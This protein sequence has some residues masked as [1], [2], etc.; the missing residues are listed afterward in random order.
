MFASLCLC[1][2]VSSCVLP[3]RRSRHLL[4]FSVFSAAVHGQAHRRKRAGQLGRQ[5]PVHVP[6]GAV[7]GAHGVPNFPG[8]VLPGCVCVC[9]CVCAWARCACCSPHGLPSPA[10]ETDPYASTFFN[11]TVTLVDNTP[12]LDMRTALQYL[13]FLSVAGVVAFALFKSSSSSGKSIERG[14]ASTESGSFTDEFLRRSANSGGR[15]GKGARRRRNLARQ[16]R[17]AGNSSD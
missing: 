1:V 4:S 12:A 7:P 3:N 8:C 5:L 16:A 6:A 10:D 9:V 13:L 11:Q 17:A 2:F 14:T 15:V